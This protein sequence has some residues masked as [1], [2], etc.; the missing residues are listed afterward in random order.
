MVTNDFAPG[1]GGLRVVVIGATGNVGTSLVRALIDDPAVAEIV[2]IARRIPQDWRPARTT[3]VHADIGDDR[4]RLVEHLRGAHAVVHLA[5]LLQPTHDPSITW[6]TN[7]LGG[8]RVFEAAAAAGVPALIHASSVAAYSPGPKRYPV[9]ESWPTHG[10]PGAAYCREKAY[11][12]RCLDTFERDHPQIR[13]VR[14]RPGFVFKRESAAQQ[15]RLFAGPFLPNRLVRPRLVPVVPDMRGLRFQALHSDDAAEAYR[16]ALHRP[17]HG[18]FNLAADPPLDAEELAALLGAQVVRMPRSA[19]RAAL[20]GAWRLHLVPS[21]PGL[22]D[23]V[24]RLPL[25]DTSRARRELGWEP[26]HTATRAIE[27]FLEGLREG[28][29]DTSTAP[30][31]PG[32][33]GSR[34]HEVA[35]GVGSRP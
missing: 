5:W 18:A 31:A 15:R 23:A 24:V 27:E 8:I 7:V 16:L 17:V 25:M 19:V 2:G 1:G 22:F 21:S 20:A 11:V 3:W 32:G 6:R 10:W 26:H 14:M 12:E 13:V 9:D 4:T 35:T 34:L 29:G 28:A 30:L 33:A